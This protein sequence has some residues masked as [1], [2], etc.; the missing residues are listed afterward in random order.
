[1]YSLDHIGLYEKRFIYL[2]TSQENDTISNILYECQV[3]A[4]PQGQF[5]GI[6]ISILVFSQN[7]YMA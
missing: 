3:R 2:L 7:L 1:M 6:K 4:D 5:F